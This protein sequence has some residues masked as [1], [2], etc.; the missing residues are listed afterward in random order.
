MH[1]VVRTVSARSDLFAVDGFHFL[2]DV[3]WAWGL[4][5]LW[6]EGEGCSFMKARS[7]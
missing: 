2:S 1:G 3:A 7:P 4:F 6:M 5:F